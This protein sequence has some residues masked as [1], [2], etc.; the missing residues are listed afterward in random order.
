MLPI[1]WEASA[2]PLLMMSLTS[3]VGTFKKESLLES[4]LAGRD[5]SILIL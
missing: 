4:I 3:R 5:V 1:R 2:L